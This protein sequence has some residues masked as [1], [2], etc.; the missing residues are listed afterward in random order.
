MLEDYIV[1]GY[2]RLQMDYAAVVV[3]VRLNKGGLVL[4]VI[5]VVTAAI[6]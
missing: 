1:C 5:L 2:Y 3:T 6:A 4:T